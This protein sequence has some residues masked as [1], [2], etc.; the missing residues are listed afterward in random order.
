M[1]KNKKSL[2]KTTSLKK[3]KKIIAEDLKEKKTKKPSDLVDRKNKEARLKIPVLDKSGIIKD[4]IKPIRE[5][6]NLK[7]NPRLIAHYVRVY[8]A[9]QRQG[10]VS[11]KTRGEVSGSTRKIYRQKGTGRARHGDIK[12][13]IFVGGGVA[14][15]P[16]M[17][18]FSLK[19]N[20][21]QKNKVFLMVL[22]EKIENQLL[23]ILED[24]S[25]LK[26][27]TKDFVSLLN[28]LNLKNEKKLLIVYS[29]KD[30]KNLVLGS[31][32]LDNVILSS[33]ESLN[34]YLLLTTSKALF[35]KTAFEILMRKYE[36]Q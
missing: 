26:P 30:N 14:H 4:E 8:L 34:P 19:I 16:K 21:K 32:N 2:K 29:K 22:K 1:E 23:M 7:I 33:V 35:T 3:Q 9:N 28:G 27:K 36:D 17:R 10:T 24:V 5:L 6:V 25:G 11:T 20:K 15:G 13:P 31:R 18:D 12:A